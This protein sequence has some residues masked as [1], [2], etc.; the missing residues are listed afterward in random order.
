MTG[1]IPLKRKP[2][3]KFSLETSPTDNIY[4]Y[5]ELPLQATRYYDADNTSGLETDLYGTKSLTTNIFPMYAID[6]LDLGMPY[7]AFGAFG[8][9]GWSVE[10]GRDRLS[11]GPGKS[12]NLVLGDHI[13]YHNVGRFTSYGE[14]FKY[15]FLTSFFPNPNE[16]YGDAVPD[17]EDD[18]DTPLVDESAGTV[19]N[20]AY[21]YG[22]YIDYGTSQNDPSSGLS[23]FLAHRLEGRLFND[24]VNLALT[25]AIIYMSEDNTLDLRVLSPTAIFHDYYIRGNANSILSIEADYTPIQHANIYSSF[26]L[27]EFALP[28]EDVAGEDGARPAAYGTIIGAQ[29]NYPLGDGLLYGSFEYAKTDPYLYL[30]D[31]GDSEQNYGEYG[32]NFVV[33]LREYMVGGI[34]YEQ[35]F[36][37]YE[38]GN[39]AIVLNGQVGFREFGKFNASLN[40]FYMMH[41]TYDAYTLWVDEDGTNG[42]SEVTTPTE[43]HD[44]ENNMADSTDTAARNSVEKT[45]VIGARGDY[46][47]LDTLSVYGQ[48]DY[49]NITNPG[50]VSSADAQSDVQLTV[51]LSYTL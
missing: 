5:T 2:L 6:Y 47:I 1:S 31:N 51:G 20:Q 32:I 33:A 17:V 7:R 49:I 22:G 24:K 39:D 43:S 40:V 13:N 9:E 42:T 10:I 28:G 37:G 8:G 21:P 44:P 35:D 16:Y 15:T 36:L 23:M 45:L 46:Q 27:D 26:L 50:N 11:W 30:R 14:N 29:G 48:L 12:G 18:P 34:N 38:Y 3:L 19:G 4:G 25:E 41:G